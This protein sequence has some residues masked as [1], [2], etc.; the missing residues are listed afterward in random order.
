[1]KAYADT[2]FI[3]SL[4][5][6]DAHT[7]PAIHLLKQEH[8][9]LPWTWLHQLELR[10]AMRLRVFREEITTDQGQASLGLVEADLH[11]GFF[12]VVEISPGSVLETAEMLSQTYT[13]DLGVRTLD[14]LHVAF[15]RV[16]GVSQFLSFD[17]RQSTLASQAGFATS[18]GN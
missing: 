8:L 12:E 17:R 9:P 2:G 6:P 16:L 13:Q 1:M 10:N 5:S 11:N 15:A 3:C 4:Y 7:E 18:P 14:I